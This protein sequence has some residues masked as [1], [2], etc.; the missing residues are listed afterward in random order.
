MST[1]MDLAAT[2]FVGHVTS[3]L[4]ITH[5]TSMETRHVWKV[6]RG[7]TATQVSRAEITS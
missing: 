7:L 2:S 6:G 4:D 3:S 5:V 1:T